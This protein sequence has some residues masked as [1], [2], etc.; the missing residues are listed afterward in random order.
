VYTGAAGTLGTVVGVNA[1]GEGESVD[2]AV[3]DVISK[4]SPNSEATLPRE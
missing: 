1:A 2:R 3:Q 4:I